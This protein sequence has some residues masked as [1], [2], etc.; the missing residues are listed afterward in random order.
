MSAWPACTRTRGGRIY[1]EGKQLPASNVAA[2]IDAG[3]VLVPEDRQREGLVQTL[4]VAHNML[5]ASL[6]NYF[7]GLLPAQRKEQSAVTR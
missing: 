2:R 6:R 1:L 7:N 3:I 4:S 5:L